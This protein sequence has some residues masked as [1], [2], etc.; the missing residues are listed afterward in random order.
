MPKDSP[1]ALK[2]A[3]R[4]ELSWLYAQR[5]WTRQRAKNIW[6]EIARDPDDPHQKDIQKLLEQLR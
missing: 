4:Y 3:A 6:K 5:T 2:K 1:E